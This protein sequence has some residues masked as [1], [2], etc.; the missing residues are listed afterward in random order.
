MIYKG[1]SMLLVFLIS[2]MGFSQQPNDS[3]INLD[4]EQVEKGYP[5]QWADM[6]ATE[7]KV[8]AD[9]TQAQSGKYSAVIENTGTEAG[10]KA[11]ALLLPKNFKGKSIHL[12]GYIKTENVTE[13]YA[14]LW[15]RIDPMLAF[16]NMDDRGVT[17]TTGWQKYEITFPLEPAKTEQIY[18][19][20]LLVGKGKMWLDNLQVT[21]DGKELDDPDLE[22]FVRE[23][24]PADLDKEFDRGSGIAISNPT[25]E[26]IV[27]LELI[28]KIWGFLKYHH[29][30]VAKGNYNWDYELFRI[31]PPYLKVKNKEERDDILLQWIKKYGVLAPCET[32]KSVPK[33]AVLQP[34]FYWM[35]QF[36]M[37][38]ELQK[39]LQQVYENRN[40]GEHY[41]IAMEYEAGNPRFDNEN[42]YDS[43]PYP[44]DGFR[45]LSL[46]KLWNI[47]EYFSPTKHLTDKNWATVLK[48]Y[49]PVFLEAKDELNYELAAVQLIGE[50]S[51]SHANLWEG[52]NKINELKGKYYPPFKL[53]F[54]EGQFVISDYFNPEYTVNAQVKV[55]DVITHINGETVEELINRWK[56]YYPASNEAARYRD[57]SDN[58]LRSAKN[59]VMLTFVSEGQSRQQEITLYEKE[60]LNWYGWYKVNEEERSF[61]ILED[62]IGYITLANIKHEDFEVIKQELKDTKGIVI[63]IRNYPSAFAPFKLGGWMVTQPTPF[64]KFTLGDVA[65]P[66]VFLFSKPQMIANQEQHYTGKLVVLVNEFSQ[67]QAEYTTMAFKAVK[68]AVVVGSQTAGADG[69]ISMIHLPGGLR[70]SISG[71]GVYYLDGAET[72]RIGIVPDVIVR[73]TIEGLKKGK[74]EVLEKALEILKN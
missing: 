68:D 40:Q 73:P 49:I 55:G 71:I 10:Y 42:L 32:C 62:N 28:G 18:I 29:P 39:A 6:G 13:G 7:Y 25:N 60:Q 38:K 3:K 69:D 37:S 8:Y 41:Y 30:E 53:S 31:L 65:N 67:S 21:I 63:D 22:V 24:S 72:Q 50:I 59:T 23:P 34:D 74:D 66:G 48:E 43:M 54:V 26:I 15:M 12:S 46:Y 52:G 47:V 64:V 35:K 56:V 45:L 19:G 58:L 16:D 1:I 51:D 27:N 61:K 44:D 20:G 36:G 33:D 2:L 17:G 57:L 14:G 9:S 4:F 70:T 5:V 11:L